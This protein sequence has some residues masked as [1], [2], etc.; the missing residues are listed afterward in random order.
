[1]QDAH[2]HGKQSRTAP[3]SF[4]AFFWHLC[5]IGILIL[6]LYAA[7]FMT[8]V[9]FGHHWGL[10]WGIA[11]AIGY[12]WFGIRQP[13]AASTRII[14][15]TGFLIILFVPYFELRLMLR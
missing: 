7:P 8:G 9:C 5:G 12:L 15:L 14:W 10:L 3:P 13:M 2:R 6:I 1:M 11:N 4:S